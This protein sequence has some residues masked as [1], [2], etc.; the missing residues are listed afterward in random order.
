MGVDGENNVEAIQKALPNGW[1]VE[2]D[3][4]S[5]DLVLL[6]DR[7][8][9]PTDDAMEAVV[10]LVHEYSGT[11][12]TIGVRPSGD[13]QASELTLST[14]EQIGDPHIRAATEVS[15]YLLDRD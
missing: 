12:L 11:D 13:E 2:Q 3:G 4:D 8:L 1:R 6:L 7:T 10:K 15:S 5:V 14:S 9:E